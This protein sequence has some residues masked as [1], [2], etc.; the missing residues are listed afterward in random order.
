[1]AFP[2]SASDL[3]TEHANG[4]RDIFVR[5]REGYTCGMDGT[6]RNEAG[7]PMAGVWVG[8]GSRIGQSKGTDTNGEY[9][10]YYMPT[11]TYSIRAVSPGYLSDPPERLVSVPPTTVDVDFVMRLRKDIFVPL[12]ER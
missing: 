12:V 1:V 8:Y 10:L 11:G 7:S 2:S 6:V 3:V 9:E 4:I 5:D